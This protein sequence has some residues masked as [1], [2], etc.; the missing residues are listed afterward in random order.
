MSKAPA[1]PGRKTR[2]D[3]FAVHPETLLEGLL[4]VALAGLPAVLGAVVQR[5]RA[6]TRVP[7]RPLGHEVVCETAAPC[8]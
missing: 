3:V 1:A 7:R 5:A 4:P 8:G 6:R 2:V